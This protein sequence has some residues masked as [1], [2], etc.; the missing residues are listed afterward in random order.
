MR[1]NYKKLKIIISVLWII[2]FLAIILNCNQ[3]TRI[4][5]STTNFNFTNAEYIE[6]WYCG[7]S[8]G[9]FDIENDNDKKLI[10]EHINSLELVEE[11]KEGFLYDEIVSHYDI[12]KESDYEEAERKRS[13]RHEFF[14][15]LSNYDLEFSGDYVTVRDNWRDECDTTNRKRYYIKNSGYT[16]KNKTSYLYDFIRSITDNLN[17]ENN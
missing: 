3:L 4:V 16:R 14:I 8:G 10:L 12:W 17:A 6:V 9:I 5:K 11:E 2:A 13:E 7:D 15:F 1:N